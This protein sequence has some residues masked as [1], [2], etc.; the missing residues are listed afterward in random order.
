MTSYM[1]GQVNIEDAQ[2]YQQY[3]KQFVSVLALYQGELLVVDDNADILEGEWPAQRTVLLKFSDKAAAQRW[4][5]SD[6]YQRL[7]AIRQKYAKANLALV[8]GFA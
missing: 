1:V 4:Y 3:E 5:H 7:V 6:E 2:G 8:N